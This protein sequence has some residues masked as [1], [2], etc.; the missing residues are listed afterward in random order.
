VKQV[1]R[2]QVVLAGRVVDGQT[3]TPLAG[4]IV[5]LADA[6]AAFRRWLAAH[7]VQHG[8]AWERLA[9]RPDRT[10]TD[11]A[12]RF[13]FLDLPSGSYGLAASLPGSGSRYG[14]SQSRARVTR[15]R[16]GNAQLAIVD[17]ALPTTTVTG[18][19]TGPGSKPVLLASVQVKGAPEHAFTDAQGQYVL[20]GLEA[21]QRTLLV[22]ARGFEPAEQAA[23]LARPGAAK[24][25]NVT[26]TPAVS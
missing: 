18:K 2:R 9:E 5:E 11:A 14:T 23:A 21:G 1:V 15:D 25:V 4:A 16:D 6:P 13:A 17:L 22:R 26:L 24:T 12:G 10:R 8:A 20:A 3:Q 7:R 19:V